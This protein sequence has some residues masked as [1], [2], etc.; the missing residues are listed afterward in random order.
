MSYISRRESFSGNLKAFVF[1]EI[2]RRQ[3]CF[4]HKNIA[5]FVIG[6]MKASGKRK[7]SSNGDAEMT[8]SWQMNAKFENITLWNHDNRPSKE[9]AFLRAFHWLDV[10]KAVSFSFP[11]IGQESF[12]N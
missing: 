7:T 2:R 5:G 9:D 4:N 6:K 11:Y 12:K 8:T 10:A 1:L 3:T